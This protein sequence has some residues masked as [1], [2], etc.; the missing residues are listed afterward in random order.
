MKLRV[1]ALGLPLVPAVGIWAL[2]ATSLSLLL[3][4]SLHRRE[5]DGDDIELTLINLG[6]ERARVSIPCVAGVFELDTP[7]IGRTLTRAV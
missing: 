3:H 4:L 6:R 7:P 2:A 5:P 1:L